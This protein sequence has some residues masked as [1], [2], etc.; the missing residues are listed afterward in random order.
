M[1]E[2]LHRTEA[3]GAGPGPREE[4]AAAAVAALQAELELADGNLD[5]LD[6]KAALLPAFLAALAGL[7]IGAD[8]GLSGAGLISVLAALVT[9]ILSVSAS[10]YAMRARAHSPGPDVDE[11]IA[12]LDLPI[13]DFNAALAAS[14]AEAINNATRVAVFKAAWLNRAMILAVLTILF[15]SLSRLTGGAAE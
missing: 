3:N 10:L 11:V 7:F 5:A 6:R 14:L 12:N 8:S 13:A 1:T 9:G 2:S 4:A 15:L